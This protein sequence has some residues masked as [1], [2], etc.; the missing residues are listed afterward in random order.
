MDEPFGALDPMT[1]SEMH[2]ELRRIQAQVRKTILIV[3]HDMGEAFAMAHADRRARRRR[4]GRARRAGGRSPRS[5]D[6]RVRGLLAAAARGDRSTAGRRTV[7]LI[8]FWRSHAG[9][10][11]GLLG[12][13]VVPGRRFHGRGGDA[14]RADRHPGGAPAAAGRADRVARERRADHPQ[15]GDV[16][17]PAA[18]AVH[19]RSRCAGSRDRAGALRAAAD[20]PHHRRR[21]ALGRPVAGRGGHGARA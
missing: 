8:E 1:R 13:H 6:P 3:T 20:H 7:R 19:R 14:R 9:E 4:A 11:G 2:E 17:F 10:L 15:P 12:Q 16:R 18:A 21:D 5:T